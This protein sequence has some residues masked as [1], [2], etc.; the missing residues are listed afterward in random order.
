[1]M[2]TKTREFIVKGLT[3][4][5]KKVSKDKHSLRAFSPDIPLFLLGLGIANHNSTP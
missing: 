2:E 4:V 5:I 1:M 3:I